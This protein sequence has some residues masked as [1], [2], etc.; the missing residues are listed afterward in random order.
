VNVREGVLENQIEEEISK[1]TILPEFKDWALETI[2]ENHDQEMDERNK[3]Y[4][5]QQ[6][7]VADTQR[8]FDNLVS[9]R[10][11][12]QVSDSEYNKERNRLHKEITQ[13][14]QNVNDT[15][16][17][18]DRWIEITERVFNFATHAREWFQNGNIQ[19]KKEILAAIGSN[20]LLIDGKLALTP[21]DW[22]VPIKESYPALEEEYRALEPTQ[23]VNASDTSDALTPIKVGWLPG[24]DPPF[25]SCHP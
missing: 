13:L 1:F 17:R 6:R 11:K 16:S 24:E 10:L 23:V 25:V 5:Q 4:E 2:R 9:M 20:P 18:A 21:N 7:T 12:E 3:I 19:T 22:L 14:R 15:E 8:Q